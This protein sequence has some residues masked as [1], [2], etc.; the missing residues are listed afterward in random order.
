MRPC[1]WLDFCSIL[2]VGIDWTVSKSELF[3][4]QHSVP[5]ETRVYV[6]VALSLSD[7]ERRFDSISVAGFDDKQLVMNSDWKLFNNS[8]ACG[9]IVTD[10]WDRSGRFWRESSTWSGGRGRRRRRRGLFRWRRSIGVTNAGRE[11]EWKEHRDKEH[12]RAVQWSSWGT[13]L[14]RTSSGWDSLWAS[15]EWCFNWCRRKLVRFWNC[16]WQRGQG[17]GQSMPQLESIKVPFP[18]PSDHPRKSTTYIFSWA[19]KSWCRPNDLEH[20]GHFSFFKPCCRR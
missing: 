2:R 9:L 7:W 1:V 12:W 8:K 14:I 20:F 10:W 19:T 6:C 17:N 16:W 5:T 18:S 3:N 15:I 13:Y 4:E 11:L